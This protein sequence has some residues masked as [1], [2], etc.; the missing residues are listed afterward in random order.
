MGYPWRRGAIRAIEQSLGALDFVTGD[1]RFNR[2]IGCAIADLT[3][4]LDRLRREVDRKR[5]AVKGSGVLPARR[6]G[7]SRA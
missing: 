1:E 2:A 3:D 4:Q 5:P 6:G 7:G